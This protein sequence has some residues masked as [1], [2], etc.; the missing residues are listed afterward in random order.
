MMDLSLSGEQ[1]A[2]RDTYIALLS[3]HCT[4]SDVRAS[5][6]GGFDP[7]LWSRAVDMGLTSMGLP[8]DIGGGGA[9][10]EDLVVVAQECGARLAPIP[11][12]E[13]VVAGRLMA[14][15]GAKDLA[16][17]VVD[18]TLLPTVVLSPISADQETRVLVPAG[19][20]AELVL[21][22][23][24]GD[25]VALQRAPADRPHVTPLPN[26]GC[27]PIA[28]WDFADSSL[29]RTV[30]ASGVT[31]KCLYERAVDDWR[32]LTSAALNG[33]RA[34]ALQ[35]G[36]NYI[37]NRKAFGTPIGAFQAVQHRLADVSVAGDG[38]ELLTFEA[39]W[40]VATG[41]SDAAVLAS[42][43]FSFSSRI[44]FM[45]CREAL[46]FHGGYGV[47]LEYDVQLYFRRAKAWPL[48][49]GDM[50]LEEQ[51]AADLSFPASRS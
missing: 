46:Q 42:Y 27:Q 9:S 35:I 17:E 31:A 4:P 2:V 7:E 44:S 10:L 13:S 18:G 36:L 20:V 26:F 8:E 24:R 40:A 19:A 45:T 32:V 6:P 1:R 41:Q 38:A 50:A 11:F 51:R 43:A 15:A 48:A 12:V 49:L 21:A 28:E 30:L 5:E 14:A 16:G 23:H 37:K 47:T 22:L 34:A 3:A 25:L 29:G 33:L 39:A